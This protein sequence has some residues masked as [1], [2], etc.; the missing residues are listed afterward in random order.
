MVHVL[1]TSV[2]M[3]QQAYGSN[4]LA[5]LPF[6]SC[7]NFALTNSSCVADIALL[8]KLQRQLNVV[9]QVGEIYVSEDGSEDWNNEGCT[10]HWNSEANYPDIDTQLANFQAWT[11]P[12]TYG[13]WHM[14]DDCFA[15]PECNCD[16]SGTA[17]QAS[18]SVICNPTFGVG[19]TYYTGLEKTWGTFAHEVGHNFGGEHSWEDGK[20]ITG[21]IM[22]YGDGY[23]ND[24][25]QFNTKYRKEAMCAHIDDSFLTTCTSEQ[26]GAWEPVCGDGIIDSATENCECADKTTSCT[27]CANCQLDAGKECSIDDYETVTLGIDRCCGG[28][29]M[30]KE[31]GA[32]CTDSAG[33]KGY[34]SDYDGKESQGCIPAGIF[35]EIFLQ[36][37]L[38]RGMIGGASM[39]CY[40]QQS[41]FQSHLSGGCQSHSVADI[42]QFCS[43]LQQPGLM[44]CVGR[45]RQNKLWDACWDNHGR[46]M[47]L[48]SGQRLSNRMCT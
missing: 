32:E 23:Y 47:R 26:M 11:K 35:F 1:F 37:L 8:F 10:T 36:L 41:H 30:Y 38:S 2:D 21:G 4:L 33:Y 6:I 27:H 42:S 20:G 19:M 24:V 3:Y 14:F 5:C 28:D 15:P 39:Y 43:P 44:L 25:I 31:L 48:A 9:L 18:L 7:W 40:R 22:D 17:G 16:G 46:C 13:L 29:G 34:C 12:N 45:A